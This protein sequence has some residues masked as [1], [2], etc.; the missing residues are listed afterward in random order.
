MK[1]ENQW[2]GNVFFFPVFLRRRCISQSPA[3]QPNN[4]NSFQFSPFL[5]L[6]RP[7]FFLSIFYFSLLSLGPTPPLLVAIWMVEDRRRSCRGWW[8]VGGLRSCWWQR[9]LALLL[10]SVGSTGGGRSV[11]RWVLVWQLLWPRQK[12]KNFGRR[13]DF[14]REGF[15]RWLRES[16]FSCLGERPFGREPAEERGKSVCRGGRSVWLR[17]AALVFGEVEMGA[18]VL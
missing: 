3:K 2:I 6:P 15:G 4:T 12:E 14:Q 18:L 7:P 17:E 9:W 1:T 13:L 11:N 5:D 10:S 16:R 8:R